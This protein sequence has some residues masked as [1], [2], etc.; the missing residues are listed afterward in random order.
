AKTAN[1]ALKDLARSF[2]SALS[3]MA[4]Q[5]LAKIAIFQLLNALT[6]GGAGAAA[7][8]SG[9]LNL[10]TDGMLAG[11]LHGGGI[12]GGAGAKKQ[13]DISMLTQAPR[14]HIGGVAGMKPGEV[15]AIL[16]AGEEVLTRNDPRHVANGGGA[17]GSTRIVNVIDPNLV[18]DYMQSSS[19]ERVILNMIERNSGSI[20]QLLR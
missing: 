3:Q 6:A 15:P 16:Q 7:V 13:Y 10:N 17:G 1:Q 18:Q 11:V 5:A 12:A 9:S 8:T 19:G 14:Y 20:R 2:A 4:A